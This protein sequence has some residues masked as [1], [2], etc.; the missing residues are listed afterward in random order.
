MK[1]IQLLSLKQI[2]PNLCDY[3]DAYVLVKG[4]ITVLG[5]DA[6]RCVTHINDEHIQTA[7][8]LDVIMPMCNLLKYSENFEISS[9]S[10]WE[11]KRN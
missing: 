3:S 1:M 8:H 4:N 6:A 7:K 5:G 2:K 11:S 10:L 9:G